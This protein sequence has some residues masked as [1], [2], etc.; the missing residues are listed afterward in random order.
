MDFDNALRQLASPA[1]ASG[2]HR[3]DKGVGEEENESSVRKKSTTNDQDQISL[4][5]WESNSIIGGGNTWNTETQGSNQKT[6]SLLKSARKSTTNMVNLYTPG[7]YDNFETVTSSQHSF[8]APPP[9]VVTTSTKYKLFKA[10]E[11]LREL[12]KYCFMKKGRSNN[13]FCL[14]KNCTIN[15]QGDNFVLPVAPGEAYVA[16]DKD[17]AFR[18]PTI[19]TNLMDEKLIEDWMNSSNTLEGWTEIMSLASEHANKLIDK[20]ETEKNLSR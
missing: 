12:G 17:S 5:E 19:R 8:F 14:K 7:A 18:E 9:K 4:A 10:T 3:R 15:H 16:K 13:M 6:Q 2:S 11:D 1:P 20:G